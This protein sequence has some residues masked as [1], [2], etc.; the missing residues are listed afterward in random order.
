MLSY[1]TGIIG[2]STIR[3][4]NHGMN[5][6]A[7]ACRLFGLCFRWPVPGRALIR[8]VIVEQLYYTGVQ[9]LP[10]IL[11]IAVL[12]GA[13]LIVQF[14]KVSGEFDLAKIT[15][16]LIVREIGPGLTA[17]LLILRSATAVTLEI[18]YMNLFNEID[19][20]EMAGID[21][22]RM[23]CLPRLI[24]MIAAI[25]CLF[26]IFDLVSILGGYALVWTVTYIPSSNFLAQMGKAIN[27]T[28]IAIGLI[29]AI[30]FGITISTICL[31]YAFRGKKQIAL[32]SVYVSRAG[33]ECFFYCLIINVF[34]SVLF[35]I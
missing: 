31:Y 21:P 32:M 7:F 30:C 18:S 12:T 1:A 16:L 35:Y 17:L 15:V 5:L 22:M 34:I 2:K 27:G 14:S 10:M 23:I 3:V 13:M 11:P 20:M 25:L 24:G 33:I 9:I 6:C 19:A 4:I 8:R 29:K 26:V 28:D